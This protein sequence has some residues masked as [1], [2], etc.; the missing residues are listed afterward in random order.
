MDAYTDRAKNLTMAQKKVWC[1]ELERNIRNV[2]ANQSAVHHHQL[3]T[4][5]PPPG[6]L[7]CLG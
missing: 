5:G 3:V 6:L 7:Q 2:L 1:L 4:K